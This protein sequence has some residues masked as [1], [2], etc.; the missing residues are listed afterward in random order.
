VRG[1]GIDIAVIRLPHVANFDDFDP[2]IA[3]PGVA[4]RY[5]QTPRELGHPHAVILPGT[6]CTIADLAWLRATG[7]AEAI[8]ERAALGAAVAGICGGYQLLGRAI[9]DP[10][11]VESPAGESAGLGLLP[12]ETTFAQ[13]KATFRVRARVLGGP[14]WLSAAAGQEVDG[15]E[16]HVGRTTGGRPWLDIATRNAQPAGVSDG[17][18]SDD[19]RVWGCY[20]HGLFANAWLRRA[21][22]DSL[23]GGTGGPAAPAGASLH[24]SLERLADAVEAALDMRRLETIIQESV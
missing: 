11:G 16:I 12:V 13:G 9:R 23:R 21:W 18:V 17:A 14:G 5:V 1:P 19:G 4:V 6:K 24:E 22:L 7:L 3:E 15:Y 20:L 10:H 2:L 8:R